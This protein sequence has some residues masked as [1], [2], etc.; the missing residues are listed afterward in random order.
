M[1]GPATMIPCRPRSAEPYEAVV[2]G[3]RAAGAATG[4]LL[5]RQG[6]RVL[7]VDRA[8][9]GSDTLS[10][11]G[12]MRAGV[13]QLS[14]W[15]LLDRVI[16]AGTPPIRRITFNY[17]D[18]AVL[19]AIK[20]AAGV[21]ALYAPRRTVLDP[22]V[23]DAAC[24]AG[25]EFR[26]GVTVTGLLRDSTGRVTGI[27]GRDR[28]GAPVSASSRVTVGADG[29]GSTIARLVEAPVRRRGTGA[30]AFIYGYWSD[31][32]VDGYEWLY[33]PGV[34]AGLIPTNDGLVCVFAGTTA[35]RFRAEMAAD[36]RLGFHTLLDE[37]G[38]DV[39]QRVRAAKRTSRL[40]SFPGRPGFMRKA[41][42]PGWALVGDA[43][44]FKDPISTHG[45]TDAFR[46]AELL[47]GAVGTA[48]AGAPLEL[49][50]ARYQLERDRLSWPLFSAVDAVARFDWDLPTVQLLLRR[51]SAAMTDEVTAQA[52]AIARVSAPYCL[53]L[54]QAAPG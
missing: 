37:A 51:M 3:A 29:V 6:R 18:D 28:E 25:A 12:L 5:A 10:T 38:P 1:T 14:R 11:H 53:S 24:A 26:F 44:Y 15:G 19:V 40:R 33:R 39:L 22:I 30:S 35:A 4:L 43:G 17:G 48:N 41:W 45:L 13:L 7:V 54:G 50:L 36:V 9:Y 16:D 47:A 32:D 49:A 27:V 34:A 23:V 8:Q 20:P 52:E 21:D 2:V 46:D 42:G 31:L